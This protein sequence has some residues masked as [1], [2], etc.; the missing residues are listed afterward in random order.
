MKYLVN[1]R[2]G[3][4]LRV[5]FGITLLLLMVTGGLAMLQASRIYE[6]TRRSPTTGSSAFRH[7]V[8]SGRSPTVSGGLA[9]APCWKARLRRRT[10]SVV[11]TMPRWH[12]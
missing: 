11:S 10:A 4:R 5:G 12:P 9:S 8:K 6:G 2:I 7:W 1:L 3:T